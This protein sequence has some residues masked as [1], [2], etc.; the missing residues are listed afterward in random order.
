MRKHVRS[1]QTYGC[2]PA[3]RLFSASELFV[4]GCLIQ[5]YIVLFL[6]ALSLPMS[7]LVNLPFV[8]NKIKIET[9]LYNTIASAS[10]GAWYLFCWL[11]LR[12]S[13]TR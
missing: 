1:L 6:E 9:D 8:S 2:Q 10:A 13:V 12:Y 3:A 5:A 4:V 11:C 7:L